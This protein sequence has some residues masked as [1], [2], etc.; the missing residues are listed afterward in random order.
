M[1][2]YGIAQRRACIWDAGGALTSARK[3]LIDFFGGDD[4]EANEVVFAVAG[5]CSAN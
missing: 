1:Q 4:D 2:R 5:L 3:A